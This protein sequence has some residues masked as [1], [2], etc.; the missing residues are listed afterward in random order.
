MG[1][2]SREMRGTRPCELESWLTEMLGKKG[3]E[4]KRRMVRRRRRAKK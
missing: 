1:E 2:R 4:E 3:L